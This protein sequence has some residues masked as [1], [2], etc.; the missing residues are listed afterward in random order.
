MP[1]TITAGPDQELTVETINDSALVTLSGTSS[2]NNVTLYRWVRESTWDFGRGNGYEPVGEEGNMIDANYY[3]WL[4]GPIVNQTISLLPGTYKFR[5]E[6]QFDSGSIDP[7]SDN[8]CQIT[9]RFSEL[10]NLAGEMC[11]ALF[12]GEPDGFSDTLKNSEI[13]F[14]LMKADGSIFPGYWWAIDEYNKDE[15]NYRRAKVDFTTFVSMETRIRN[16]TFTPQIENISSND[17]RAIGIATSET[18]EPFAIFPVQAITDPL[19]QSTTYSINFEII[20]FS[21]PAYLPNEF[22]EVNLFSSYISNPVMPW[23]VFLFRKYEEAFAVQYGDL[24]P[25]VRSEYQQ[26]FFTL[27]DESSEN[28]EQDILPMGIEFGDGRSWLMKNPIVEGF[29]PAENYAELDGDQYIGWNIPEQSTDIPW[30]MKYIRLDF[31]Y[32]GSISITR[33]NS[34]NDIAD[35]N[36]WLQKTKFYLHKTLSD[37]AQTDLGISRLMFE[38]YFGINV[39]L[40]DPEMCFI[41]GDSLTLPSESLI[42]SFYIPI[43]IIGST[44]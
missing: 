22:T 43:K 44:D 29:D 18:A 6:A 2:E 19:N 16:L 28:V 14:S 25:F 37:S 3:N 27:I 42:I 10:N 33:S 41:L 21:K 13:W 12:L 24:L 26:R 30:K 8:I 17:V 5:L 35:V 39:N 32:Q 20:N 38:F 34:K 31:V 7:L 40:S 9:V 11:K 36:E 23:W 15:L 4:A 1:N